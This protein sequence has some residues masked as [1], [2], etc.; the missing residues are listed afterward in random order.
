MKNMANLQGKGVFV[1]AKL[2]VSFPKTGTK[3]DKSLWQLFVYQE[4]KKNQQT[5]NYD[6]LGR[7]T[8]FVN[9]PQRNL[10]NGDIVTIKSITKSLIEKKILNNKEYININCWCEI[11]I[12]GNNNQG[13]N[14]NQPQL[15][16]NNQQMEMPSFSDEFVDSLE[17]PF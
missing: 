10:Q 9:N 2:R 13:A 17:L 3:K 11:E 5:G 7:Y 8:I 4:S 1:G 12:N 6:E 15:E 14:Q 16:E